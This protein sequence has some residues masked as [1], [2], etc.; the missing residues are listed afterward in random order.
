MHRMCGLF[1]LKGKFDMLFIINLIHFN[2][3]YS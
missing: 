2:Y 1:A 3:G